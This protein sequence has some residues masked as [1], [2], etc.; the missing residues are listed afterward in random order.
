MILLLWAV[1]AASD[2][3]KQVPVTCPVDG[4]KFTATEIAP[5]PVPISRNVLGAPAF[6]ASVSVL[7]RGMSTDG[8]TLNSRPMNSWSP[9]R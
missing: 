8:A 3:Q 9:T 1:L 7:G 2:V 5:E 6:A 4:T